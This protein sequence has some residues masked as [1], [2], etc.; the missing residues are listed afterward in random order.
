MFYHV[1]YISLRQIAYDLLGH[2]HYS[3]P[4]SIVTCYISAFVRLR[5]TSWVIPIIAPPPL[6]SNVL[7]ISLRQIVYDLLGHSHYTP[8]SPA[9]WSYNE[10][11]MEVKVLAKYIVTSGTAGFRHF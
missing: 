7:Y 9:L 1:L 6:H 2:S 3:P 11:F 8:P 5:T 10:K 4:P